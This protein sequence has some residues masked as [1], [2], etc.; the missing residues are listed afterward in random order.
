MERIPGVDLV[1]HQTWFGGRFQQE[2][3]VFFMQNPVEPEIFLSMFPEFILPQE[4]KQKWLQTRTGAIVG[5]KT[6]ERFHWKVG[7][8]VPIFTPLWRTADGK[9]TWEF[10]LVGIFD[11]K[12]KNTDTMSLFFRYDYFDEARPFAKGQVGWYTVR[13]KD[14][15]QAAQVAK[16]IDEEFLNSDYETKTAPE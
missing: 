15:S 7:D 13:V 12:A 6:A 10:D 3:K 8:K 9:Q 14:P 1:S 2:P 5:R 11:G 4:Q 16:L